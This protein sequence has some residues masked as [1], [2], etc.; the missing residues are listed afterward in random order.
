MTDLPARPW[1][2]VSADVT[3]PLPSG[4]YLLV[5][6]DAYSRFP[7]VEII[8]STSFKSIVPKLHAIFA[9]HGVPDILKSDNGPPFNSHEFVA[10]SKWW[11]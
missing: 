4:E 8:K 1:S 10:P 11:C 6:T 2:E 9:R 3:G 5:V 7:E